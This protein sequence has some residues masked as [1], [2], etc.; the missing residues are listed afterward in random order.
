MDDGLSYL[1]DATGRVRPA[2]FLGVL[3]GVAAIAGIVTVYASL[4]DYGVDW[5]RIA[6]GGLLVVG[7]LLLRIEAAITRAAAPDSASVGDLDR[8]IRN[9]DRQ[10]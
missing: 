8:E 10:G 2:R 7:G 6:F 4:A 5:D 3:G 1:R 9:G